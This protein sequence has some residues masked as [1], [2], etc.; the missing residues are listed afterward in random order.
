MG[1]RK[2]NKSSKNS[3]NVFDVN[4]CNYVPYIHFFQRV[5]EQESK[6]ECSENLLK[7]LLAYYLTFCYSA[8]GFFR[9]SLNQ[10][11]K[12]IYGSEPLSQRQR[13][14]IILPSS[15][16]SQPNVYLTKLYLST[17]ERKSLLFLFI[18]IQTRR[19]DK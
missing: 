16:A 5:G 11:L 18:P 2:Q 12:F 7:F 10:S 19:N 15:P 6:G 8:A 13:F 3:L 1:E 4:A 14:S 9:L 17:H